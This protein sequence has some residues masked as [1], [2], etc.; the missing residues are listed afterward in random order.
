[1]V[2]ENE[3]EARTDIRARDE[4]Q[5]VDYR[6]VETKLEYKDECNWRELQTVTFKPTIEMTVECTYKAKG[7]LKGEP[8]GNGG[9][10]LT[11]QFDEGYVCQWIYR[12]CQVFYHSETHRPFKTL[13]GIFLRCLLGYCKED[14]RTYTLHGHKVVRLEDLG[15]EQPTEE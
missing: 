3:R 14:L 5:D 11:I 9:R 12:F 10:W 7:L 4:S 6:Y 15:L 13:A 1:M 8:R 2:N